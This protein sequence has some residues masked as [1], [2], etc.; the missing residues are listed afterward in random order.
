MTMP[1]GEKKPVA[2]QRIDDEDQFMTLPAPMLSMNQW[3]PLY[4]H[5]AP[6][7]TPMT[8]KQAEA[9]WEAD[10]TDGSD[11]H[12]LLAWKK[13]VRAVERHHGIVP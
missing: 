1:N 8:D 7:Q 10:D 9:L 4:A 6:T 3:R 11:A 5:P 2:W 13:M 12:T